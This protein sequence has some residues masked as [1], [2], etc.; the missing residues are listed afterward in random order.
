M[1][2]QSNIQQDLLSED[3][4]IAFWLSFTM[5][6]FISILK[7]FV[8]NKSNYKD[9]GEMIL[10]L[11]IDVCTIFITMLISLAY[12][13]NPKNTFIAI[14]GVLIAVVLCCYFRKKSQLNSIC[15]NYWLMI[16]YAIGDIAVCLLCC[17]LIVEYW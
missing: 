9:W 17:Y 16:L 10:E 8:N 5:L 14:F 12:N 6:L 3:I 1:M 13:N 7:Y 2:N 15:E 11:P 4:I